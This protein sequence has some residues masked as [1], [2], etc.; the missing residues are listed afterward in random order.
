MNQISYSKK[1]TVEDPTPLFIF[2]NFNFTQVRRDLDLLSA[3]IAPFYSLE[4]TSLSAHMTGLSLPPGLRFPT[5]TIIGH[6]LLIFG[7]YLSAQEDNFSIWAL[8]LGKGGGNV[9]ERIEQGG[10]LEWMRVDPGI[11]LSKGSW[12]RAVC[13]NNTVVVLG[14]RERSIATD[15]NHRQVCYSNY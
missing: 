5:G 1:P 7:T 12:N 2:S 8:D 11:C 4:A 15:Y 9:L 6:H 3:P 13:W 14:D 10:E